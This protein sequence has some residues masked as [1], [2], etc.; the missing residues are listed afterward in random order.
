MTRMEIRP[1][2]DCQAEAHN[3]ISASRVA[4][5]G[6]T[7]LASACQTATP[8][9]PQSD[10]M[11]VPSASARVTQPDVIT[12]TLT[13][14]LQSASSPTLTVVLRVV[15]LAPDWPP[16]V[17]PEGSLI[18]DRVSDFSAY[19]I[20]LTAD[21]EKA[22]APGAHL[23]AYAPLAVSPDHARFAYLQW[24]TNSWDTDSLHML[25]ADGSDTRILG[26]PPHVLWDFVSWLDTDTLALTSDT[27]EDARTTIVHLPEGTYQEVAP[28]FPPVTQDGP[29]TNIEADP[30]FAYYN[31]SLT[32]VVVTRF[33]DNQ[34][35]P[36]HPMRFTYE[37]WDTASRDRLWTESASGLTATRPVWDPAGQLFAVSFEPYVDSYE[38]HDICPELHLVTQEGLDR[39]LFACNW[40]P[41]TWSTDGNFLASWLRSSWGSCP[42]TPSNSPANLG[43]LD[44]SSLAMKVYVICPQ[45]GM[46]NPTTYPVWSPDSRFLAL[47]TI[48]ENLMPYHSIIL[49]LASDTMFQLPGNIRIVGWIQ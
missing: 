45:A 34:L 7:L 49:D 44:M 32:R 10:T 9:R 20:D 8:S 41:P 12:K 19:L 3:M 15:T 13:P 18:V 5:V 29:L 28:V 2:R 33:I 26:A 22:L 35:D 30:P 47:E 37:L 17:V 39:F 40:G 48:D 21:S 36:P 25:G 1:L 14:T 38:E 6:L 46:M 43:V 16:D 4:F 11:T 31:P 27:S 42:D 23:P 24:D